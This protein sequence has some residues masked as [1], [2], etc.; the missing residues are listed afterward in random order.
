VLVVLV[1]LVT[2]PQVAQQFMEW[3][4]QVEAVL[5]AA[6]QLHLPMEL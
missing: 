5:V 1:V 4:L 2:E 3:Y 6:Q